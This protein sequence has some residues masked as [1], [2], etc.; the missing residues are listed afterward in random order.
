MPN[1]YGDAGDCQPGPYRPRHAAPPMMTRVLRRAGVAL[2][3]ADRVDRRASSSAVPTM[4]ALL[5]AHVR[6]LEMVSRETTAVP[7]RRP[8]LS[9]IPAPVYVRG[10]STYVW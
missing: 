8:T 9:L 10:A 6:W 4:D 2:S 3:R 7:G 5:S 1:L